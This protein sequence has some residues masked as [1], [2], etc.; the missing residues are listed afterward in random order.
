[1][2]RSND[3]SPAVRT[4]T[5][6]DAV[7]VLIDVNKVRY[8]APFLGRARSATEAATEANTTLS[9]MRRRIATFRRVGLLRIDHVQHPGK[10]IPAGWYAKHL[11][12]RD[13]NNGPIAI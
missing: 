12:A 6:P 13:V 8:L 3:T 2:Q 7:A 11:L 4:I 1:M 10:K 5:A 9:V